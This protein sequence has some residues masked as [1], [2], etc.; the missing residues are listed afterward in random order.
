MTSDEM[1]RLWALLRIPSISADPDHRDDMRWAADLVSAELARAGAAV[2]IR[3][4]DGHPLVLGDVPASHGDPDAPRVLIYG[5]YD[6]QPPGHLALWTSPPFEPTVREGNL[7]ARGASDDKGNL[8][9]L[10][11]AVQRLAREGNLPVRIG[12]VVDGEEESHGVSA[13]RY[14]SSPEA[15]GALACIVYDSPMIAPERP[16]LCSG[17]RGMVPRRIRVR[18]ADGD[19]HSGMYGGAALNATHS[20]MAILAA[21]APRDGRLPDALYEG[22]IPVSQA[23]RD[24]WPTLPPGERVLT[25]AGLRPADPAAAAQFYQR[26]LAGPSLDVHSLRCANPDTFATIVPGE[27]EATLSLRVAPGQDPQRMGEILDGLLRAACPAG[28]ELEI[29]ALGAALPAA[30]DPSD[31]VLQAA[32]RGIAR[33]TGWPV[34]PVRTGGT[35][36]VIAAL[37]AAG[38]PTILT[39]FGLQSDRIHSPDE[40][41]AVSS[42]ETGTRAAMAIIEELGRLAP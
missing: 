7:Y 22:V 9:M 14:L 31:P 1:D 13:E 2:E 25:E 40:H 21:V 39:G 42:L 24:I 6:V 19:G 4:T 34:A 36:P 32:R 38:I 3:T 16:A 18:T 33:A 8:F 27:A 11:A 35:I 37:V 10:I 26:T 23:E 28:A 15:A 12:F 5:H 20:L 29:T 30:L 41:L 17:L